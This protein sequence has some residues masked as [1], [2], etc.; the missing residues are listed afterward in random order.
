MPLIPTV[1]A[2]ATID[3]DTR[4]MPRTDINEAPA[5]AMAAG[6]TDLANNTQKLGSALQGL[7]DFNDERVTKQRDFG[8]AIEFEKLKQQQGADDLDAAD[9]ITPDGEGFA[10]SRAKAFNDRFTPFLEK[11][12]QD[13]RDKYGLQIESLR[14]GHLSTAARAQQQQGYAYA[15]TAIKEKIEGAGAAVTASPDTLNTALDDTIS[16]IQSSTLPEAE[17]QRLIKEAKTEIRNNAWKKTLDSNDPTDPVQANTLRTNVTKNSPMADRVFQGLIRQESGGNPNAVSHKGALGVTQVMPPTA[18]IIARERGDAAVARMSDGELKT[19]F[20]A[21]PNINIAYGRHY[22][23]Q[24]LDN[25]N[26]D[27]E[28]ALVAY[29]GGPGRAKKWLAAGRNDAVLPKETSHYYRTILGR[30]NLLGSSR[31]A[32]AYSVP[33]DMEYKTTPDQMARGRTTEDVPVG[34]MR[35]TTTTGVSRGPAVQGANATIEPGDVAPPSGGGRAA[36]PGEEATIDEVERDPN[37]QPGDSDTAISATNPTGQEDLAAEEAAEGAP[38]R[39]DRKPSTGEINGPN[40]LIKGEGKYTKEELKASDDEADTAKRANLSKGYLPSQL[41]ID[42]NPILGAEPKAIHDPHEGDDLPATVTVQKDG[43]W[44]NVETVQKGQA[45]TK[46]QVRAGIKDGTIKGTE[47]ATKAEALKAGGSEAGLAGS[48]QTKAAPPPA[49]DDVAAETAGKKATE[50]YQRRWS[51]YNDPEALGMTPKPAQP[52]E[53]ESGKNFAARQNAWDAEFK[54]RGAAMRKEDA[55]QIGIEREGKADERA[56]K[57]EQ[58]EA[59]A[60]AR[61]K[62]VDEERAHEDAIRKM[63][64]AAFRNDPK[65]V[66]MILEGLANGTIRDKQE[67]DRILGQSGSILADFVKRG[68]MVDQKSRVMAEQKRREAVAVKAAQADDVASIRETGQG[69]QGLTD[70]RLRA[71]LGDDVAD[72]HVRAQ[73]NAQRYFRAVDGLVALPRGAIEARINSLLPRPGAGFTDAQQTYND[74]RAYADKLLKERAI[75]PA[76]SVSRDPSVRA[77]FDAVG[78]NPKDPATIGKLGEARVMAQ[79]AAGI[80]ETQLSPITKREADDFVSMYDSAPPGRKKEVL[81]ALVRTLKTTFGPNA[82]RAMGV[83]LDQEKADDTLRRQA[84]KL[85]SAIASGRDLTRQEAQVLDDGAAAN[86]ESRAVNALDRTPP[87]AQGTP[88]PVARKSVI[89]PGAIQALRADPKMSREFDAK[90]GNGSAHGI[91]GVY[92]IPVPQQ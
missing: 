47:Y 45:L 10:E 51:S 66:D 29:N 32:G 15:G 56:E 79:R 36:A 24:Q 38:P 17:K 33:K 28:A 84:G 54:R 4:L 23:D 65:A 69:V 92:G 89:P 44:I 75:D 85:M 20:R 50:K 82:D 58:R 52:W 14:T 73:A 9:K 63:E 74:A 31:T 34:A 12:P 72:E 39:Q 40:P 22:F 1:E 19:H 76:E 88:N 25:F 90:Y 77:A 5:R 21:N 8:T 87:A 57:Q 55:D 91:L 35:A 59:K 71:S 78:K 42:G 62:R 70:E 3:V 46:A 37:I 86:A 2:K 41:G 30:V 49:P 27:M 16:F 53:G 7:A 13:Q 83:I 6:A 43:K 80:P 11:L 48:E 60:D 26:G 18:R 64:Q 68:G 81:G 67:R 61:Q